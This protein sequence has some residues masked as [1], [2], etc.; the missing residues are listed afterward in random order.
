MTKATGKG[1]GGRRAGAGAKKGNLNALKHGR[2]SSDPELQLVL[3]SIPAD[4]RRRLMPY[5]RASNRTIKR[6]LAWIR[7]EKDSGRYPCET[8]I[9]FRAPSASIQ[10]QQQP[11]QSNGHLQDLATRMTGHGFIGAVTFLRRHSPA[12]PVIEMV[13]DYFD[14]LEAEKYRHLTN[15]AGAIR[16]AIHEELAEVDGTVSRCPYCPWRS[17]G[18][19]RERWG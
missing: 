11:E 14:S 16:S 2:R 5:L 19:P 6:R 15:P 12:F 9:P 18:L 1:R 10:Q 17:N 13:V 7:R 8:V 3:E 4:A